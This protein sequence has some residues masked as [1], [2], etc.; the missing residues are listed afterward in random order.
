MSTAEED[1]NDEFQDY[2]KY[3]SIPYMHIR[4]RQSLAN[5]LITFGVTNFFNCYS[6]INID[7]IKGVLFRKKK[8]TFD[9]AYPF[10]LNKLVDSIRIISCFE[11]YMKA[12][13]LINDFVVHS[14]YA[15]KGDRDYKKYM[16]LREEQSKRPIKLSELLA[17]SLFIKSNVHPMAS[18]LPGITNFTVTFSKLLSEK[19]QEEIKLPSEVLRIL[20]DMNEVR[21]NVHL[22][23]SGRVDINGQTYNDLLT[24]NHFIDNT[25]H[26]MR[27]YL[28]GILKPPT[29]PDQP[30]KGV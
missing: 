7:I 27:N 16:E 18:T 5:G 28:D 29:N 6:I 3:P 9:E 25:I 17:V 15:K 1:F 24:L 10:A 22:Y 23:Y 20:N 11:N 19:Y 26:P 12:H 14:I 4:N 13:L 30:Q 8:L 21:N 2:N